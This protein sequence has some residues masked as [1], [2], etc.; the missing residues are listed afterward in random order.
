MRYWH[1]VEKREHGP[2]TL[3][4]DWT[5]EDVPLDSMF[6]ETCYDIADMADRC[7]RGID[8][9]YIAR[10]RAMFEGHEFGTATLGS[11]YASDCDP[12][13]DMSNGISGY[14]DDLI[15]DAVE[16][17]QQEVEKLRQ[18]IETMP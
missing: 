3:I 7:N 11:C 2:F 16:Q 15:A 1:E 4:F 13:D 5:Y 8:T 6:D 12:A 10:V 14:M 9:H 18:K 17:A